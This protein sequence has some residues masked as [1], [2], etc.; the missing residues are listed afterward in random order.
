MQEPSRFAGNCTGAGTTDGTP[1]SIRQFSTLPFDLLPMCTL[2]TAQA[3]VWQV[4]LQL[5]FQ[6]IWPLQYLRDPLDSN[7]LTLQMFCGCR[8][9]ASFQLE[10]L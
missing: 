8:I 5:S 10:R 9:G 3:Q 1:T 4:G 7:L 6:M 2:N